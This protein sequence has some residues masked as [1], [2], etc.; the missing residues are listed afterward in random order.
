MSQNPLEGWAKPQIFYIGLA[1]QIH[2]S[3]TT[4]ALQL[5]LIKFL[6]LEGFIRRELPTNP[7]ID[8]EFDEEKNLQQLLLFSR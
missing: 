2:T 3:I 1:A 4:P 8:F 5:I 6:K 7:A